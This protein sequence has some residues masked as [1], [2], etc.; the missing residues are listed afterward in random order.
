M[1]YQC[2]VPDT[3][4]VA[5]LLATLRTARA[6]AF[7]VVLKRFGSGNPGPLSFPRPGWTLAVDLPAGVDGLRA[8]LDHLDEQVG[9]AGG[10]VYLAKDARMRPEMVPVFYPTFD[11]WVAVRDRVDPQRRWCSDQAR[12][13]SL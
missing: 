12:R 2:V 5:A 11:R 3:A 13:L 8:L 6:P 7:L 1:Q 9:A 10:A 4:T